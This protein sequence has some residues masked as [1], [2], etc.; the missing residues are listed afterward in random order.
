MD[1]K[2]KHIEWNLFGK[3]VEIGGLYNVTGNV[4]I[5]PITGTGPANITL[6][7]YGAARRQRG[8]VE[9]VPSDKRERRSRT[10]AAVQSGR[11]ALLDGSSC[12]AQ[13]CSWTAQTALGR[14]AS[15]TF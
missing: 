3:S 12:R 1:L 8:G 13:G 14:K 2:G 11:V 9:P 4:L 6:S 5:L 10:G 15:K 7:E